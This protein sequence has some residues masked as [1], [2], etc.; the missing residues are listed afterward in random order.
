MVHRHAEIQ[1][2][3][4]RADDLTTAT[5]SFSVIGKTATLFQRYLAEQKERR[6]TVLLGLIDGE[7]AGY[8]TVNW[9][10]TYAPL[11]A[12]QIPELQDLNVLPTLR[13]RGIG[14]ALIRAAE[15]EAKA[16]SA[17][18]GIAVGL[19]P[20]YNAAQRLYVQLGYV[21]DGNGITV[22]ERT[23]SEAQTITLD[24]NVVLHFEKTLASRPPG[25]PPVAKLR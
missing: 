16:R 25:P 3:R 15:F 1:V 19:H 7:F 18:V 23:V 21:P 9:Q 24:D 5:E 22:S 10:P 11:A 12:A 6:R 4:F 2:R 8:V 14:T 17:A 20:G 13:R